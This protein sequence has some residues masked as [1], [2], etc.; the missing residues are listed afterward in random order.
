MDPLPQQAIHPGRTYRANGV[1]IDPLTTAQA[2]RRV[3]PSFW[4]GD[5][6]DFAHHLRGGRRADGPRAVGT[7]TPSPEPAEILD[8]P[9]VWCGFLADH[10]GHFVAEHAPRLL[11]SRLERPDD[12]FLFMLRPWVNEAAVPTWFWDILDWYGVPREQVA[13]VTSR[14][15]FVRELRILPQAEHLTV[16]PA[17]EYLDALDDHTRPMLPAGPPDGTLFVSRAGMNLRLGGERYLEDRLRAAGVTV[18]RPEAAPLREQLDLYASARTIIFSEGSA[19]HGRQLLGRIDQDVSVL[20]R[21]KGKHVGRVLLEDRVRTLDYLDT[22]V[23]NL[24]F[25]V[26]ASGRPA[27]YHAFPLADQQAL[28]EAFDKHGVD[29]SGSWSESAFEQSQKEDLENWAS[30]VSQGSRAGSGLEARARLLQGALAA[31]GQ[32]SR[33]GSLVKI[34]ESIAAQKAAEATGAEQVTAAPDTIPA[35]RDS[36]DALRDRISVLQRRLDQIE[37]SRTWRATTPARRVGSFLHHT[38]RSLRRR[39]TR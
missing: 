21:R 12:T 24:P 28:V 7:P 17:R 22:L 8:G 38:A 33:S 11:F 30:W 13:F 4:T 6:P 34:A 37:H 1:R 14:P 26:D 19:M 36:E 9:A 35:R 16:G 39:T 5:V 18:I 2:R 10:F 25:S 27:M 29:L 3:A 15:V 20:V 31:V 23:G 32:L